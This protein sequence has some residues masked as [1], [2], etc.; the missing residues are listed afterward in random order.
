MKL[1]HKILSLSVA[2]VAVISCF[3]SPEIQAQ[4]PHKEEITVIAPYEPTLPD[5]VKINLQPRIET[6]EISMPPVV[7]SITPQ[8]INVTHS[9]EAIQEASPANE[10]LSTIYRNHIRAGIGNYLT[11]Y[12]EFNAGSLRNS[13]YLLS[14][15]VR[16]LSTHG[17]IK[18]YGH[19]AFSDNLVR[20]SAKRFFDELTLETEARYDHNVLHH[21]GFLAAEFP[22]TV[23]N[24]SKEHLR[25]RFNQAGLYIKA[26][27]NNKNQE[28]LH[29]AAQLGYGFI[30]DLFETTEH[31]FEFG[32]DVK[33]SFSLMRTDDKQNLGLKL[34]IGSFKTTDSLKV[35]NNTLVQ[36]Q[37]Y[38][39]FKYQ[40]YEIKVG[41]GLAFDTDTSTHFRLFPIAEGRL[42][43]VEDR[44]AVFV[45]IDG[46]VQ[47]NSFSSL[48]EE[49]PFLHSALEYRN[50]DHKLRF[51]G[52]LQGSAGKRIDIT[53]SIA[54][55][56]IGDIPL[57]VN[58]TLP[59]HN[60]FNIIY[61]NMNLVHGSISGT[62]AISQQLRINTGFDIFHYSPDR[63]EKAWHKP[64]F[65]SFFEGWYNYSDK[66]AFRAGLHAN[67]KSWAKVR[68]ETTNLFEALEIK[69]WL[70]LSLGATYRYS[71]Q[72]HFFLD[73]RNLTA[74][75]H[76]YWYNYP[77]QRMV[78]MAGAGFSF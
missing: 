44:L 37:P 27:S 50:T 15:Q 1:Q 46:K 19:S 68:N 8:K 29:Y 48:V 51:Y 33:S 71:D 78:V 76:F 10:R 72:L 65:T 17:K 59:P 56:T 20:V 7:I 26:N 24:T 6:E 34:D 3:L 75:R 64:S 18:D 58:D 43:L 70:D 73:A 53:A 47:K 49:N 22:D 55:S 69:P 41:L 5:V 57:F 2:L 62:Y 52:G 36:V 38:Y 54:N 23:F 74:G 30:N 31:R 25:Q 21:Y 77:S 35:W 16:H 12:I 66:L 39:R 14:T 40:E 11:P 13:K 28:G 61:D 4:T 9:T 45:G 42:Q 63:E 67:G 60:R 32:S